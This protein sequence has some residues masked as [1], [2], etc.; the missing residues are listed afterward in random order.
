MQKKKHGC[1][2]PPQKKGGAVQYYRPKSDIQLTNTFTWGIAKYLVPPKSRFK[3]QKPQASRSTNRGMD[4]LSQLALCKPSAAAAHHSMAWILDVCL[5]LGQVFIEYMRSHKR[6]Q[7]IFWLILVSQ[8]YVMFR[9]SF[10]FRVPSAFGL[11]ARCIFAS[12]RGCFSISFAPIPALTPKGNSGHHKPHQ[13]ETNT[14][15]PDQHNTHM[16]VS[17]NGGTPK[18]PQNDHF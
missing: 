13:S 14:I 5:S 3:N 2:F 1:P 4:M 8:G 18:T 17:L 10:L 9:H 12:F 16:G 6:N 7:M 11:L 15:Q